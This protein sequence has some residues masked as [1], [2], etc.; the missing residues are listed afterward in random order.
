MS[1]IE[2][3]GNANMKVNGDG[4]ITLTIEWPQEGI[5]DA[6][7][8]TIKFSRR[9]KY[10][11]MFRHAMSS[12]ELSRMLKLAFPSDKVKSMMYSESSLFRLI[13]RGNHGKKNT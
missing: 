13:N 12:T 8:T 7:T 2:R 9:S 6:R 1:N 11:S 3:N 10:N 4:S 5:S